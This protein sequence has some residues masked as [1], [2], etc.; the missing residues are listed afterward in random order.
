MAIVTESFLP[1]INGVANSV[2]RVLE[3]LKA[4]GHEAMVLAPDDPKGVP[5]HYLGFPV[6]T[7][8]SLPLPWYTD[9]RVATVTVATLERKLAEFAPDVVHAAA[10]VLLGR[11]A[12]IAAGRLGLPSV[13][14]YQTDVP[15]YAVRYGYGLAESAVWRHMRRVHEMATL[16]LAP[17]SFTMGQLLDHGFPR[18]GVWGRG[19]DAM[20]FQPARRDEHLHATWAPHGQ[21]VIGYLGRLGAEKRVSD[22][23]VLDDIP[24]TQLVV[25][26]DGPQRDELREQLPHAIFTGA[27]TGDELPRHLASVDVFVHPGELETF[28][29]TLQEASACALP[30]VAPRRGGP[31]D[32]VQEGRTGHLYTPGDMTDLHDSVARLVADPVLR[33]RL[34]QSARLTMEPRTWP[35][36]CSQ[37]HGYYLQA[38]SMTRRSAVVAA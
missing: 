13:A 15:S 3:S 1:Q 16:T 12:L 38:L 18:V 10:P 21:C 35:K 37:L 22:L 30:V 33:H 31:I 9:F 36:L 20:R 32:I 25:I 14:L 4:G 26:G 23:A 8:G 6:H 34:G 28:G 5:S 17:S 7:V 27:K 29:Q 2:L 19:V 11:T 24:G